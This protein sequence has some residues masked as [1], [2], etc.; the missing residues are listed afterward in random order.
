[1]VEKTEEAK[2]APLN[3]LEQ[4]RLTRVFRFLSI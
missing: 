3:P 1:M 2:E 4:E